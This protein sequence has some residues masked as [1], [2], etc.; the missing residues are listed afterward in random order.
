MFSARIDSV[1][2][3]RRVVQIAHRVCVCE[4]VRM[5]ECVNV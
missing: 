2:G 5:C 3:F 1:D 4:N